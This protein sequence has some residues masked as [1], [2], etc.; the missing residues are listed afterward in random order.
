MQNSKIGQSEMKFLQFT[1]R[2]HFD[3][4]YR[5]NTHLIGQHV[6]GTYSF[7]VTHIHTMIHVTLV[8]TTK[9][10]SLVTNMYSLIIFY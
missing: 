6:A 1:C 3:S 9:T 4:L 8:D 10:Q 5:T 7:E 2:R